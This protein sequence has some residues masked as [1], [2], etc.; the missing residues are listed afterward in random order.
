KTK[1]YFKGNTLIAYL[2]TGGCPVACNELYDHGLLPEFWI[3]LIRDWIVGDVVTHG[4]SKLSL[5]AI[6]EQIFRREGTSYGYTKLA[7]EAG[8]ANNTIAFNYI[9]HL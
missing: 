9:E 7:K 6:V 2:I 3:Q 8:L 5:Q 4:K 1:K